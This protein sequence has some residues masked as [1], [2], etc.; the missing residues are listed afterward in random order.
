MIVFRFAVTWG[1]G[2]IY[3]NRTP[4]TPF[5]KALYWRV[6]LAGWRATSSDLPAAVTGF[7][8]KSDERFLSLLL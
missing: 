7:G 5:S 6:L 3:D 8:G 4:L 1:D 2:C